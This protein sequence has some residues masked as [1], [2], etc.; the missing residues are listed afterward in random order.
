MYFLLIRTWFSVK[1]L[2]KFLYL[3]FLTIIVTDDKQYLS[4][5]FRE[6]RGFSVVDVMYL[7]YIVFQLILLFL[8]SDKSLA[9][10]LCHGY[11]QCSDWSR[12]FSREPLQLRGG[13]HVRETVTAY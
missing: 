3:L 13:E 2:K 1:Y 6:C 4:S 11:N 8:I 9:E 12:T 5:H 7:I 10:G